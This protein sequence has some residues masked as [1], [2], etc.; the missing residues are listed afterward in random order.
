MLLNIPY[1]SLLCNCGW[2]G[3][4]MINLECGYWTPHSS[5]DMRCVLLPISQV[6]WFV[7]RRYSH[8]ILLGFSNRWSTCTPMLGVTW[9]TLD[10]P[11]KVKM[12]YLHFR[13]HAEYFL[14]LG[15]FLKMISRWS[16]LFH[17]GSIYY[18]KHMHIQ[19]FSMEVDWR[20]IQ[21]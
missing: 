20:E 6:F 4:I 8:N 21:H 5:R 10:L 18:I 2:I 14:C 19:P 3:G 17:K 1:R 15:K 9:A 7:A 16:I 13:S 11:H 12:R